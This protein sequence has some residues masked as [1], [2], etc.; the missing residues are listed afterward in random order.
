MA[1]STIH[2]RVTLCVCVC[3]LFGKRSSSSAVIIRETGMKEKPTEG[4]TAD[5]L[6]SL[7]TTSQ[8]VFLSPSQS[9]IAPSRI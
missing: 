4:P 3:N 5:S 1:S 6:K 7:P 8:R 9:L 2:D